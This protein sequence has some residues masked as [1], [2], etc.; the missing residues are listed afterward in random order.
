MCDGVGIL[1]VYKTEFQDRRR[2]IG[3][4]LFR[5]GFVSCLKRCQVHLL[6]TAFILF[7]KGKLS[8]ASDLSSQMWWSTLLPPLCRLVGSV[9]FVALSCDGKRSEVTPLQ[10]RYHTHQHHP[11]VWL[12]LCPLC[13]HSYLCLRDRVE[14]VWVKPFFCYQCFFCA[15]IKLYEHQ[16]VL[17]TIWTVLAF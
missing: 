8:S 5:N 6:F 17:S 16:R 9:P 7:W 11:V 2:V 10:K 4:V 13:E 14:Y 1:P 3:Y 15:I 12:Y